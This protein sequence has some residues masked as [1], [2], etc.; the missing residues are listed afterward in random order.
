MA[1]LLNFQDLIVF[2]NDDYCLI[3]KPPGISSIPERD[4]TRESIQSMAK[5]TF[6]DPQLCHRLDKETSGVLAIAKHPAAYRHLSIQFEEREVEKLYHAVA[7]GVHE[8]REKTVEL[9]IYQ[10]PRG[11]VRIDHQLGKFA[12]TVFDTLE[13][14]YKHTLVACKPATGRMHQ[15]RIHLACLKA[16]IVCDETYG[17]TPVFL[18]DIKR[19][20]N[21]KKF[22]EEEPIMKRVALHAYQLT[23]KG[24]DGQTIQVSAQYP[25]DMKAL[26]SQLQKSK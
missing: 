3:N 25:K 10:S 2:E 5:E 22:T 6:E 24:L 17:G 19:K 18:S 1:K 21:L 4:V 7:C 11:G 8:F 16:P 20:V 23:F 9:P 15:I 13:V 14:Y 26:V 12:E